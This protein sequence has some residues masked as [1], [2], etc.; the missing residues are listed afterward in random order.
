MTLHFFLEGIIIGFSIAAP[1]GPIGI[2]C[3]RRSLDKGILSGLLTGMGAASADAIYGSI[4]GFGLTLVSNFLVNN[5]FWLQ[6]IGIIFLAYLGIKTLLEKPASATKENS[7]SK[8]LLVDYFSGF[9][10]TITNPMTIIFFTAIF[11]GLGISNT[12]GNY[13]A[14]GLLV[15]GVFS[16][17]ALWWLIL[18]KGSGLLRFKMNNTVLQRINR[19]SGII[20]LTF[21]IVLFVNLLRF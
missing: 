3:I 13:T 12:A 10:L 21:A 6:T 1:V 19:I 17:S 20:I 14:A 2:L 4:A 8:N 11:A 16:G 9:V 18:S 7:K 15:S 5:R